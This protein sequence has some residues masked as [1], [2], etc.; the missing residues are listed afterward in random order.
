MIK[1]SSRLIGAHVS[2]AGGLDRAVE[3]AAKL[4]CNCMQIFSGSPRSW[5]RVLPSLSEVKK[6]F[7]KQQKLSVKSIFTHALYLINLTSDNQELKQKSIES[8]VHE[9]QFD[10]LI[11][12]EGVVVHL[13][14]HMGKGWLAVKDDLLE[15]LNHILN[16]TPSDSTLLIENSAGQKGKIGSDLSEIAWLISSLNSKRV[17]WCLDTCHAFS[18]GLPL[19][20]S[21]SLVDADHP[22]L[23]SIIKTLDLDSSLKCIH[24]NDSK[25]PLG[26]GNDRHDN[27]LEG[28]IPATDLQAF[29]NHKLLKHIPLIT[30]VPGFDGQGPDLK[31]INRIKQLLA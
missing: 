30:E 13:G 27:I 1:K 5:S 24:L 9:L 31:N 12:G 18:A 28:V 2:M 26:A 19:V 14:S 21:S 16:R 8:L 22:D 23:V 25:V 4:E 3:R 17:N 7:S 15:T 6:L 11:K 29:V 20:P 10:S